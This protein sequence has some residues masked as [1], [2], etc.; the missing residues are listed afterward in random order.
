MPIR[1]KS[2][3]T[4]GKLLR[5]RGLAIKLHTK[6]KLGHREQDYITNMKALSRDVILDGE[7]IAFY[8]S[9]MGLNRV[10]FTH[11]GAHCFI[12]NAKLRKE[13]LERLDESFVLN[14][15]QTFKDVVAQGLED[16]D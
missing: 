16:Y 10:S 7:R 12:D 3:K 15:D 2:A 4:I 8:F 13:L 9:R 6:H 14:T 1:K 5:G 11:L